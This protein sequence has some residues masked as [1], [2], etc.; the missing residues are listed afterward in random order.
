MT[1]LST[2]AVERAKWSGQRTELRDGTIAG[3]RLR[4][5]RD[6]TKSWSL[7]FRTKVG[8]RQR[9][10]TLGDFDTLGVAAARE[11]AR[12]ALTAVA[13]GH[14]PADKKRDDRDAMTF[15]DLVQSYMT[16]AKGRKKSWQQDERYLL[17]VAEKWSARPVKEIRR[18]DVLHLI[19]AVPAPV[20][21]NRM[22]AALSGLFTRAIDLG[23]IEA[24]PCWRVRS[25]TEVPRER[26]LTHDEIRALWQ[27][28]ESAKEI[29]RVDDEG[30]PAPFS[31]QVARL[32]QM[33]LVC[34]Q[35]SGETAA[36]RWRDLEL[37]ADW[38]TDRRAVAW[39]QI[40]RTQTKNKRIHR[41]YLAPMALDI[42]REC[43]RA[44]PESEYPFGRGPSGGRAHV[45]LRSRRAMPELAR[46]GLFAEPAPT[47]HDLRRTCATG[48]RK[49]GVSSSSVAY[50]L[51]HH[52]R[53]GGGSTHV[54][55]R[56]DAAGEKQ[57]A[58]EV[59]EGAL[60]QILI[61]GDSARVLTFSA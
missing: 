37:P 42:L 48:M 29:R 34:G 41:V 53:E 58:L 25:R 22:K 60:R 23:I 30:S 27:A 18:V 57:H 49:A 54:Y 46:L 35:R 50:V 28:C 40:P 47:R 38:Q 13:R 61:K 21:A 24:N 3:L 39:W 43:R 12:E 7:T 6:G 52:Q 15:R 19:E 14:D 33:L 36:M 10:L 16:V 17:R 4:L 1:T 32:L 5:N 44:A 26:V 20:A 59:W 11:A 51:G 2:K 9:R 55:D 56:Y 45:G 31:G 8:N